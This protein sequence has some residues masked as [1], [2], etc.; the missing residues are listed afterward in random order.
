VNR[1]YILI[2]ALSYEG[3]SNFVQR[4]TLFTVLNYD[5]M[6]IFREQITCMPYYLSWR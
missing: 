6:V 5:K 3:V 2:S 1:S 4:K